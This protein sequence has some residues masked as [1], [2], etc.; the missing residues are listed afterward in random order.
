M[1]EKLV[2]IL[3]WLQIFISPVLISIIIGVVVYFSFDKSLL[4]LIFGISILILGIIVGIFFAERVRKRI[5]IDYFNAQIMATP[6]I[7]EIKK[8]KE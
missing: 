4:G 8:Q 6:D 2:N 3:G 7:K 1:I 5:G